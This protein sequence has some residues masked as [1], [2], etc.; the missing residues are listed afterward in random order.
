MT[1]LI[2]QMEKRDLVKRERPLANQRTVHVRI[3]EEG[4]QKVGYLIPLILD[5]DR[6][7]SACFSSAELQ[8]FKALLIKFFHSLTD[9]SG[10]KEFDKSGDRLAG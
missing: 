7:L 5:Y 8:T 9:D 6:E 2:G 10:R 4:R 1:R 3:L